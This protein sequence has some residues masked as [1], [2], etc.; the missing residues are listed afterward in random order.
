[1]DR[2]AKELLLFACIGALTSA[3]VPS[4][5]TS[6]NWWKEKPYLRP[7]LVISWVLAIILTIHFISKTQKWIKE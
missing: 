4:L 3:I 1:M 2:Q 7:V 6:I 5:T